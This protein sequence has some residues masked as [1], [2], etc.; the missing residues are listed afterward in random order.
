MFMYFSISMK[1]VR[2]RLLYLCGYRIKVDLEIKLLFII[3]R[4][5]EFLSYW[6]RYIFSEGGPNKLKRHLCDRRSITKRGGYVAMS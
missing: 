2:L 4:L 6:T 1:M 3:E 5:V